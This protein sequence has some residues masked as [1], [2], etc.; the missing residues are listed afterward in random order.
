M[1]IIVCTYLSPVTDYLS[2][3]CVAGTN[4][5]SLIHQRPRRF[6]LHLKHARV[7]NEVYHVFARLA[8]LQLRGL[9]CS[10]SR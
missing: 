1:D 8:E 10:A 7:F 5:V 2:P 9:S 4:R 6:N 3:Q